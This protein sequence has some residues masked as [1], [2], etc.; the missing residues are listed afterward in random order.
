MKQEF[1]ILGYDNIGSEGESFFSYNPGKQIINEFQFY[2]ATQLEINLS[3]EK[4]AGR[5]RQEWPAPR[6]RSGPVR[7]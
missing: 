7:G 5:G 6:G 3:A 1:H 4:A 2:K